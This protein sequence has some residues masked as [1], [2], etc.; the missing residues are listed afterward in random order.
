MPFT[1]EQEARRK[2]AR[3]RWYEKNKDYK[4]PDPVKNA[5]TQ[6]KASLKYYN[7]NKS[8]INSKNQKIYKSKVKG[9]QAERKRQTLTVR[10]DTIDFSSLDFN[11]PKRYNLP[12]LPFKE[13]FS[14]IKVEGG[15][16]PL[17]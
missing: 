8:E 14:S 1:P 17:L 10:D 16:N 6:R 7:K 11:L 15:F 4:N 3:R 9:E 2:E 12:F 5:E 13:V